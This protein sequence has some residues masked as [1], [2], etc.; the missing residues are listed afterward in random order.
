MTTYPTPSECLA[1]LRA[2]DAAG[3]HIDFRHFWGHTQKNPHHVD[4]ACF[5]QFFPARFVV[6]G[7]TYPAAEHFMMAEKA[8]T[9]GDTE[10]LDAI[11]V[12]SKPAEAKALGRGV[13]GFDEETWSAVRYDLVVRGNIAKFTQNKDMGQYL[14]STGDSVLVEASPR[15]RIWG[16]GLGASNRD[17]WKPSLWKGTNLLGFALMEVRERLRQEG[18]ASAVVAGGTDSAHV[19]EGPSEKRRRSGEDEP[20]DTPRSARG[21]T[22]KKRSVVQRGP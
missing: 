14:L 9:F 15:D 22:Q 10:S 11:L 12:A 4:A 21:R 19:G 8:R 5:S 3:E 6:D 1:A 2:R 13:T 20:E 16:I 17:A 18:D 7:V